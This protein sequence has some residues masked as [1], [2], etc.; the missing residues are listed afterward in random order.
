MLLRTHPRQ[1]FELELVLFVTLVA[2][3]KE[4]GVGGQQMIDEN[5]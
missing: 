1:H 2:C 5:A 3:F 4:N